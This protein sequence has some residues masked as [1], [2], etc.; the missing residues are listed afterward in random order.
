MSSAVMFVAVM[1]QN[2]PTI[3]GAML[4]RLAVF[5]PYLAMIV[6][7]MKLPATSAKPRIEAGN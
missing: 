4:T 2:Q 1:M 6:G 3:M 5:R 7:M